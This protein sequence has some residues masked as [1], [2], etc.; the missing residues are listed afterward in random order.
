MAVSLF[1]IPFLIFRSFRFF[2]SHFVPF[3]FLPHFSF[4]SFTPFYSPC[5]FFHSPSFF[6]INFSE[7]FSI[8]NEMNRF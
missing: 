3:R 1:F 2:H 4:V 7:V 6:L 8:I 5:F